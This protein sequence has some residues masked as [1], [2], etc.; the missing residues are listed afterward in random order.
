MNGTLFAIQVTDDDLKVLALHR[1]NGSP[2]ISPV[3]HAAKGGVRERLAAIR[4]EI[5]ED[6]PQALLIL[7]SRDLEFR[8]FSYPFETERKVRNAIEFELATDYP[9][10]EYVHDHVKALGREPGYH[11]YLA[12]LVPRSTL[13]ERIRTVEDAGFRIAGI[14]SDVSTL[15]A[16]FREEEEA[17][18]MDTGVRHTLFILYRQGVPVL[19]RKIPIG[20]RDE[21][22]E[23][24]A[25]DAAGL[26]RLGAE[27][28]RTLHSFNARIGLELNRLYVTGNLVLHGESLAALKRQSRTELTLRSLN[29]YGVLLEEPSDSTDVNVFAPVVGAAFWRRRNGF[30]NFLREEFAREEQAGLSTRRVLRWAWGFAAAFLLL[31]ILSYSLDLA[32][33]KARQE[34]LRSEMRSTFTSA[35]PGVTRVVD[36]LKQAKNLLDA[37]RSAAAG[38]TPQGEISLISALQN[39]SAAIPENVPFQIVSLF[40]ESGRMEVYAR[41]DSFKT[42]NTVQELLAGSKEVSQAAISNARHRE[43]GQDVEFK[44][45][46]RFAG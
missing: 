13:K 19:L 6:R 3:A 21:D 17:L 46:I 35:F 38:G 36:E 15:G 44:L 25:E 34:F 42:V 20:T 10:E 40:W 43:E 14:T 4:N 41:T 11:A 32:A 33:L 18:V 1:G 28:K 9:A 2:R 12:A 30:F 8:E 23:P 16:A 39:I 31:L 7:N 37:E 45:S 24:G 26:A 22:G 5:Q 27:I 29:D